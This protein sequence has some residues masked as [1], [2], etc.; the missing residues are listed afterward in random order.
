MIKGFATREATAI[1]AERF[2][3]IQHSLLGRTG[4]HCSQAGFGCYRVA[5]G[6]PR[7]R[8]ALC[9]ALENGINLIDT[10]ANY[11]DGASEALV[12][13]VLAEVIQSGRLKREEIVV[14]TK[15]GY[16]Q[17]QNYTL[18][19]QRR[20]KGNPF[21]ELVAYADGLEH[22]IHPEF[23]EDQLTRSLERL[24]LA[25]IDFFLLH[26]PEYYLSWAAK[27]GIDLETARSVYDHRIRQALQ[28]L[29]QEVVRGR[30]RQYGISSNTFPEAPDRPEFTC[31]QQVLDLAGEIGPENHFALIQLPM[32]LIESG[33]ILTA[34]QPDR[35]TLLATARH[36]GLGILINRPLDALTENGLLRLADVASP[37]ART[38]EAIIEAIQDLVIS[39]NTLVDD[40]LPSIGISTDVQAQIETQLRVGPALLQQHGEF[41]SYDYWCQ[42]QT[43]HLLPRV[44]GVLA[45]LDRQTSNAA[46]RAWVA[47]HRRRLA[48]ALEAVD[49]IYA[50]SAFER[51]QALKRIVQDAHPDWSGDGTLSQLAIRTLRSTE[52]ISSVLVGMRRPG[53]VTDVLGELNRPTPARTHEAGWADVRD[54]L[55]SLFTSTRGQK[56]GET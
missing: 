26:N 7:H 35:A 3:K 27:Q 50:P 46:S 24:S 37:L 51:A 43:S 20:A 38:P 22:C 21:P 28:Y 41:P 55:D 47:A 53:Y 36:A 19:Q 25:T 39:E 31:L 23:L 29:E 15:A 13:K 40:I 14:V 32:N 10:S 33:A 45:Y 17:G 18:S 34:N 30:I 54:K 49:A 4:L 16:L 8:E 48:G 11:A 2:R 56:T 5:D 44:N 9:L 1:H 6:V 52:G 42:V 12:G